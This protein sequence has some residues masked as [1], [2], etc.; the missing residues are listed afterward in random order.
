VLLEHQ[1]EALNNGDS[2]AAQIHLDTA[3]VAWM[4]RSVIQGK[5]FP[6]SIMFHPGYLLPIKNMSFN[7]LLFLISNKGLKKYN[8]L[9]Y[10]TNKIGVL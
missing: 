3:S 7:S 1:Q 9:F 4:K 5:S 2:D 8:D 10:F 6:D